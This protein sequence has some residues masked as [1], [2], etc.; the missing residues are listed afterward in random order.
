MTENNHDITSELAKATSIEQA[1]LTEEEIN[2]RRKVNGASLRRICTRLGLSLLVVLAASVI[3][4]SIA[5][6]ILERVAPHLLSSPTVNLVLASGSMYFVG[7]LLG[8][9]VLLRAKP[10]AA[11]ERKSLRPSQLFIFLIICFGGMYTGNLVGT[12]ITTVISL[13]TG[14]E[15]TNSVAD[16]ISSTPMLPLFIFVVILAPIFEELLFRKLMMDRLTPYGQWTAVLVSAVLF[17]LFHCNLSQLFYATLLGVF[18]GFIYAR[19]GKIHH[20][21]ILHAIINFCGS[22]IPLLV[23]RLC[24]I[25]AITEFITH[26]SIS[27]LTEN[28]VG[29]L[30]YFA[31]SGL[32]S[33]V[34]IGGVV[35]FIVFAVLKKFKLGKAG[36]EIPSPEERFKLIITSPGIIIIT[37]GCLALTIASLF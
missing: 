21:I 1:P 34:W 36:E 22:I 12:I 15:V 3:T 20:T 10:V 27:T 19:T 18:L 5:V 16:V 2:E 9:L 23:F 17:G 4:Q 6:V 28:L 33:L 32:I 8:A 30:I 25:E 14:S 35:L 24:D 31:Y 7:V 26:P 37:L 11:P 29:F 13:I